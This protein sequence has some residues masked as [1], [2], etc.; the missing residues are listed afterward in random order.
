MCGLASHLWRG[1]KKAWIPRVRP[2]A[3][4]AARTGCLWN[5]TQP[6][7]S[8][9]CGWGPLGNATQTCVRHHIVT[10]ASCGLEVWTAVWQKP[11]LPMLVFS[12]QY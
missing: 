1:Q 7:R 8:I 11:S 5:H 9:V 12:A 6:Q 3:W 2:S 4:K 10:S